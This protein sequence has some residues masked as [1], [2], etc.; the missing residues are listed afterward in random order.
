MAIADTAPAKPRLQLDGNQLDTYLI[1]G[2]SAPSLSLV[3][4]AADAL[5]PPCAGA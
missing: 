1:S 3:A 5:T 2:P 4:P